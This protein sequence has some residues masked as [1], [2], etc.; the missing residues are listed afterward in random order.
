[1]KQIEI[2]TKDLKST[3][4]EKSTMANIEENQQS[5]C[6]QLSEK[7]NEERSTSMSQL[8]DASLYLINLAKGLVKPRTDDIGD[9]VQIAP[10]HNV[11]VAI[12]CLSEFRCVT[13]TKIEMMK[14]G[15]ELIEMKS[16]IK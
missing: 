9:A 8:N 10:T 5:V 11:E 12:K 1:M 4:E 7:L 13:N 16:N 15:K 2:D 14:L 6:I 3:N